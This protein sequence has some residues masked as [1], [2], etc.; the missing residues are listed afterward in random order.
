MIIHYHFSVSY[1][2]GEI[3]RI[4][5]VN[6]D[7]VGL[8]SN[9][10]VEVEFYPLRK[11]TYVYKHGQFVLSDHVIK[12]YYVPMIPFVT[13]SRLLDSCN[14]WWLSFVI[15]ILSIFYR[16]KYVVGEYSIAYKAMKLLK[17][18][19]PQTKKII[20]IHGAI[21]EEMQYSLA[22]K[23]NAYVR[24]L[25][26]LEHL[27]VTKSDYII[28]QSDEMKHHIIRKYGANEHKIL[29]YRCGVDINLFYVDTIMRKTIRKS[30]GLS[31]NIVVFVYSGGMHKWQKIK[32]TLL[33]FDKYLNFNRN[34]KFLILTRNIEM[35]ESILFENNL[36]HLKS[37]IIVKSLAI[38]EVPKYLNAADFA[39]LLRDNVVMNA[40]A[41]PTKLS[42]YFACGLPVISTEVAHFWIKDC[43][44][45][46]VYDNETIDF[47][48]MDFLQKIPR[49][50]IYQFAKLNLSLSKDRENAFHFFERVYSNFTDI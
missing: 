36:L 23:K 48:K 20:D 21:P 8:L 37:N 18:L 34:S 2:S 38:E 43:S 3:R 28:C 35:L 47:E 19:S 46:Y 16:V 29:V 7:I 31:D 30:L 14:N 50:N 15:G 25:E 5:N 12:K 32:E 44:Y 24:K 13:R 11:I 26:C 33:F 17:I 27:G 6:Q 4:K 10:I 40:V 1:N 45:I 49:D 39:F 42:E 41:F 9:D 22:N